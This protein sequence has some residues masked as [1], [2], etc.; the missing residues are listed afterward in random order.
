MNDK[1]MQDPNEMILKT[2]VTVVDELKA[3][4]QE[5]HVMGNSLALLIRAVREYVEDELKKVD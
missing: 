4:R 2:L 5:L 3:M 1:Y